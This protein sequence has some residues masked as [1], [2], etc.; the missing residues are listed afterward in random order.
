MMCNCWEFKQ[1]HFGVQLWKALS[2]FHMK[3]CGR[4]F[5]EASRQCSKTSFTSSRCFQ[6]KTFPWHFSALLE[7]LVAKT[8]GDHRSRSPLCKNE[9]VKI[10]LASSDSSGAPDTA[11]SFQAEFRRSSDVLW[12]VQYVYAEVL[13]NLIQRLFKVRSPSNESLDHFR[14][15]SIIIRW[16]IM[17]DSWKVLFFWFFIAEIDI[18][19]RSSGFCFYMGCNAPKAGGSTERRNCWVT[20]SQQAERRKGLGWSASACICLAVEA[21]NVVSAWAQASCTDHWTSW[22]IIKLH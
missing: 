6:T 22:N 17:V 15:G 16:E 4:N 7:P 14:K 19:T 3:S 9:K 10:T 5:V 1:I 20:E 2:R 21:L 13:Q 8:E 12:P 11:A 18:N